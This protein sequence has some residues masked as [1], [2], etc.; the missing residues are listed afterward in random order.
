MKSNRKIRFGVICHSYHLSLWQS[1]VIDELLNRVDVE[2]GLVSVT[3]PNDARK[4][5]AFKHVLWSWFYN[6][7]N[8]KSKHNKT[9][10]LNNKLQGIDK[11]NLT[12]NE[13]DGQYFINRENVDVLGKKS[14][15]F[16]LNFTCQNFGGDILTSAK[17]GM[18]NLSCQLQR[19]QAVGFEGFWEVYNGEK[20]IEVSIVKQAK[21]K[22]EGIVLKEGVLKVRYSYTANR[23]QIYMESSRW[24]SNVCVDILNDNTSVFNKDA[25]VLD[26]EGVLPSNFQFVKFLFIANYQNIKRILYLN[27]YVD[28]WNIGIV[29]QP[30]AAFLNSDENAPVEWYPNITKKCFAADPFGVWH[31]NELHILFEAYPFSDPSGR[32]DYVNYNDGKYSEET[33]VFENDYHNSYPFMFKHNGEIYSIPESSADNKV[34]LYKLVSFPKKWEKQKVLLK[35]FAGVDNTLFFHNNVWWI[36]ATDLKDGPH[37]NLNLFYSDDLLGDWK[38][39]PQ[40]PVKTDVRS[41]RPAG[42]IFEKDG[43]WYRP[44][45]DYS[46]KI[47]GRVVINKIETISKTDYKEIAAGVVNPYINTAFP[48][49]IHTLCEAGD[50]TIVDGSKETFIFSNWS[51][52]KFKVNSFLNRK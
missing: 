21:E 33:I 48:G 42:T 1:N 13:L 36:F 41:A 17:F 37:F 39:H 35:D 46:E 24:F 18:W 6:F 4:N 2:C 5:V 40:N 49:K 15:D 25:I 16:I 29:K 31:N 26:K 28:F 51:V 44:S 34:E 22:N 47:E 19:N 45:M 7:S 38:A 12:S 50:Y 43:E 23:D 11:I 20:T 14:L 8:R 52:F 9:I 27:L 3:K 32:I 30:I 10:N